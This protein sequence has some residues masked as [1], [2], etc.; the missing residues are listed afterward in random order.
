MT[1]HPQAPTLSWRTQ[2]KQLTKQLYNFVFP[3][4]CA[5][6]KRAGSLLCAVC[7]AKL[8]WLEEPLCSLCGQTLTRPAP[9]CHDCQKRP[10]PLS[11]IRAAFL[12]AAPIPHLIHQL[13]YENCF[14]LAEPLGAFMATAWA[15]WQTAVDLV[16][17]IPLHPQRHKKRGY[18]QSELLAQEFSRQV[19]LPYQPQALTRIRNTQPQ[20]GLNSRAR[21]RNLDGAFAVDET[22]VQGRN[23]LL[24]DDVC[25]TGATLVTAAKV[26][27]AAEA[28]TVA[29]YCLARA[30]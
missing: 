16:I 17:P 23:I 21:L 27:L 19:G 10:L 11:Q 14:A 29:G 12:F 4:V 8:V 30:M 24:I 7:Q 6:C 2:A 18:N 22:A 13:K 3:P 20:V 15:K 25:T 26:L 1:G 5:N 28:Q 9:Y